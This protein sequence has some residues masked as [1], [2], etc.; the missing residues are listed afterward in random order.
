MTDMPAGYDQIVEP[1]KLFASVLYREESFLEKARERL[2]AVFGPEDHIGNPV[3]FDHTVFYEQEMGGP[4]NRRFISYRRLVHQKY[5]AQAKLKAAG[6]EEEL[7]DKNKCRRVNIDPGI[8]DCLKVVLA[9]FKH[10]PHKIYLD[11]GVW[12]DLI[13]YYRKGGW[14]SF[15]W[16]FPDF[17]KGL[18]DRS[19]LEIRQIYKRQRQ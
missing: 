8:L 12:A 16:T 9:S 11:R 10:Q 5:L 2:S 17:K 15:E 7:A 4:L 6:I 3:P 1:V 14:V 13:L 18:H 19:L